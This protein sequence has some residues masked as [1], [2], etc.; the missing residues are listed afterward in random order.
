MLFLTKKRYKGPKTSIIID[1]DNNNKPNEPPNEEE[2]KEANKSSQQKQSYRSVKLVLCGLALAFECSTELGWFNFSTTMHQYWSKKP[3]NET[4]TGWGSGGS[5]IQLSAS[6]ADH[7]L[8]VQFIWFAI[9]R[10]STTFITI[11]LSPE[12]IISYHYVIICGSL[13][14]QY[15]VR[16]T[17]Q[18]WIAVTNSALGYGMSA[19]WPALMAFTERHLRLSDQI[20][21]MYSFLSGICSL[22][23]PMIMSQTLKARPLLL[24]YLCGLFTSISL[25]L[26]ISVW[27]WILY[28]SSSSP[29]LPGSSH[30]VHIS[31]YTSKISH[32]YDQY[33]Q[34]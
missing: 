17:S 31:S 27:I 1:D 11:K 23:I 8:A 24:F 13:I 5:G 28:S 16:G 7:L 22:I 25:V 30:V 2:A 14:A 3:S 15:C 26:F 4:E 33:Q 21:S 19:M 32:T 29:S 34:S 18:I 10:L 6:T 20:C 12:Y 9:G